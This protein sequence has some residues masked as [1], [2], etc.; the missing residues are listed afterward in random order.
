[1]TT[2][3]CLTFDVHATGPDLR[4]QVIFDDHIIWDDYPVTEIKT[5]SHDFDDD[6]EQS[7]VLAFVLSGKQAEHTVINTPGLILQDRCI[8]ITNMACDNIQ[9]GHVFSALTQYHHDH[10]GTTAPITQQFYGIMGCNGRAELRFSTPVYLW[11]LEN[12]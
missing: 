1:M 4:L 7:H 2:T 6:T 3:A 11:L 5:V 10:N 9:L 8:H 12:M